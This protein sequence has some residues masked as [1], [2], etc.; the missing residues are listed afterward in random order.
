MQYSP[1]LCVPKRGG[2][3]SLSSAPGPDEDPVLQRAQLH[4]QCWA[5]SA[6]DSLVAVLTGCLAMQPS[7]AGV[8][9]II[10]RVH[11]VVTASAIPSQTGRRFSLRMWDDAAGTLL[12]IAPLLGRQSF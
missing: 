2:L 10:Q 3:S 7:P 6:G 1:A 4:K 5:N 12:V 8:K 9:N 11:V